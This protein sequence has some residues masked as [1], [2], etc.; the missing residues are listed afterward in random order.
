MEVSKDYLDNKQQSQ[1]QSDQCKMQMAF[2]SA[3]WSWE[4][5][6]KAWS[7][8]SDAIPPDGDTKPTGGNNP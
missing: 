1:A 2:G 4:F 7:N 8:A 6:G 3:R 5:L